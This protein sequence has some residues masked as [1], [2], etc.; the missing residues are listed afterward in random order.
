MLCDVQAA[1]DNEGTVEPNAA[2]DAE[3]ERPDVSFLFLYGMLIL[4]YLV[5]SGIGFI[6]D[7]VHIL[8]QFDALTV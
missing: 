4:R 6:I 7:F 5:Q 2:P 1:N 8:K 3:E